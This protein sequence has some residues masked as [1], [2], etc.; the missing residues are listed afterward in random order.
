[1]NILRFFNPFA[2]IRY[3]ENLLP[4]WQQQGAVYFITFRLVDAVPNKLRN[5]WESGRA[6]WL[7]FHPE[8]WSTQIEQEYHN[9]F[10]G[11]M[12]RWLDAGHGSCV[13]RRG[14]CAQIVSDTLQ[15]FDGEAP[16]AHFIGRY[17]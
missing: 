13:L 4:H 15:Y 16:C 3:T 17:A 12:E 14:D 11:A 6:I 8:P 1:M 10:S 5:Q 9:R 7:Q 2:E